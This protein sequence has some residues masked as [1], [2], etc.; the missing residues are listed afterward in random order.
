MAAILSRPQC[1][2]KATGALV[3]C[4]WNILVI[5]SNMIGGFIM[6]TIDLF[7]YPCISV[8]QCFKVLLFMSNLND[9]D[10][11][12]FML[13]LADAL[14]VFFIFNDPWSY[15]PLTHCFML[16]ALLSLVW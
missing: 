5:Q 11:Y 4:V 6:G 16:Y 10:L 12:W 7:K 3:N 9:D 13:Y 1:T 8:N 2:N 14:L 15:L